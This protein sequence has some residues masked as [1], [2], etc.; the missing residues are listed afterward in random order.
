MELAEIRYSNAMGKYWSSHNPL[1]VTKRR[2]FASLS[3][4]GS[5]RRLTRYLEAVSP[6]MGSAARALPTVARQTVGLKA[7]DLVVRAAT[8]ET[9]AAR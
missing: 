8:V 7:V 6:D 1:S 5:D 3:P 9:A 2:K 4:L